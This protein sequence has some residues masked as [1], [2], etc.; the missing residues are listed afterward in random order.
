MSANRLLNQFTYKDSNFLSAAQIGVS[1]WTWEYVDHDCDIDIAKNTMSQK[2]YDVLPIKNKDSSYTSFYSTNVWGDYS[3][4]TK[5][6]IDSSKRIYYKMSFRDLLKIFSAQKGNR[7]FF[8]E[9][10]DD[11]VGLISRVNF[12]SLE[13]YNFLYREIADIEYQISN[14]F[15]QHI[16]ESVIIDSFQNSS[17]DHNRRLVKS[18]QKLLDANQNNSIFHHLYFPHL[19]V[20]IDKHINLLPEKYHSLSMY[21]EPF[22]NRFRLL[23]NN[24]AHPTKPLISTHGKFREISEILIEFDKIRSILN[25]D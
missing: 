17:D 4:L 14:C 16:D 2:E 5:V 21:S 7:Y 11:I 20:I 24:I 12:N 6:D 18:Y 9:T 1:R 22:T 23:R 8:L 3:S 25:S 10:H 15:E 13:V 19:G